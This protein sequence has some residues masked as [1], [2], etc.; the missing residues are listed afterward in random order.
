[1]YL[2]VQSFSFIDLT[3]F[4]ATKARPGDKRKRLRNDNAGDIDGYLGPWGKFVDEKTVM[5]PNEVSRK[6]YIFRSDVKLDS[7]HFLRVVKHL[8][9]FFSFFFMVFIIFIDADK[10]NNFP[11]FIKFAKT[12]LPIIF[13]CISDALVLNT[14]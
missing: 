3:V 9:F 12:K 2:Q 14:P 10:V 8:T 7:F 11:T 13:P 1:M 6:E 5:K 4:E